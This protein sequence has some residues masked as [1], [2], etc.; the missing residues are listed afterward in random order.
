M[1]KFL[2]LVL[3]LNFLSMPVMAFQLD[4]SV[5]DEIRKTYNPD[6]LDEDMGLPAL[7]KI[8]SSEFKNQ[9]SEVK[10][11][12]VQYKTH[13]V[14]TYEKEPT[15]HVV[16]SEAS[17]AL[18]KKGTRIKL[19]LMNNI[20]DRSPKGT[21]VNFVSIYP[22]TTTYFSI[23]AGTIF[24][25][26]IL[27]SHG[28]QLSANGGLIVVNVNTVILNDEVQPISSRVTNANYKH[29]YKN[30]IKGKRK[31]IA[32]VFD[33]TKPG[34]RFFGRTCGWAR[35][36]AE[37]GWAIILSPVPIFAG[38]LVMGGN[39]VISPVLGLFYKG[40]PIYFDKGAVF[41]IKLMQDVYLYN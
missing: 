21:R 8:P 26:E 34:F 38:V 33:S 36:L 28:P 3:M 41:D 6:K 32:S 4:T 17:S 1:K 39:I 25:G 23:P 20:S 14:A 19:K 27:N 7:P 35:Y 29:I 2:S 37:N 15:K 30:N 13:E 10:T 31:Y 24:K 40:K 16:K 22:V 18:L 9:E 11:N 12:K 5:N